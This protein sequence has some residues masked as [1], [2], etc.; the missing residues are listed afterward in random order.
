MRK[1]APMHRESL[2]LLFALSLPLVGAAGLLPAGGAPATP[3]PVSLAI[4][5]VLPR[6]VV[7]HLPAGAAAVPL[8][9]AGV[10]LNF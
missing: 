7:L 4:E 10:W 2:P 1:T 9:V 3:L 6:P 5:P 8:P